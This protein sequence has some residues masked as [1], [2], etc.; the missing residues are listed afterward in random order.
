MGENESESDAIKSIPLVRVFPEELRT[1]FVDNIVVQH[2]PDRFVVSFFEVFPPPILGDSEEERRAA[3]EAMSTVEAKCVARL[4][5]TPSRMEEFVSVIN[6]NLDR[7]RKML[8]RT[9]HAGEAEA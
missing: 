9:L 7:Y 8:H 3:M 4:V 6:E 2:Q 5:I 1:Y